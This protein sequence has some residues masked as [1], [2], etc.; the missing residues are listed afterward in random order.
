VPQDNRVYR[1]AGAGPKELVKEVMTMDAAIQK[2]ER[3][4]EYVSG[5]CEALSIDA[6]P[7]LIPRSG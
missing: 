1:L 2:A 3:K 7:G 5:D 4:L 6:A